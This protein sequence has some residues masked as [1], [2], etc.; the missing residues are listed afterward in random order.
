MDG[1]HHHQDGHP[2]SK[3][4]LPTI[5]NLTEGIV[6]LLLNEIG[7]KLNINF[8]NILPRKFYHSLSED[9]KNI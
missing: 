5:Q 3:G 1:C 6:F 2:P 4:W 8:A 9:S 7:R